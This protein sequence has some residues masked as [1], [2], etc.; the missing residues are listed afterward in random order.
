M[1]DYPASRLLPRPVR[2]GESAH[3]QDRLFWHPYHYL[4]GSDAIR[5][6]KL[7]AIPPLTHTLV[8]G[9]SLSLSGVLLRFSLSGARYV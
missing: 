4:R 9:G 3:P 8:L 5:A 6:E 7:V 1:N 2:R